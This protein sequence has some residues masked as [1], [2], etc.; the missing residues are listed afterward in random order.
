LKVAICTASSLDGKIATAARDPVRFTSRADRAHLH[1]QR[2]WADAILIGAATIRA[3]D[4]PLLPSAEG[5]QRRQA[6]SR[7]PL[8]IRAVV[9]RSLDLPDGRALRAEEGSPVI[10]FTVAEAGDAASAALAQRG[11]E[12]VRCGSGDVDLS[13]ALKHLATAHGAERVLCEGGGQLNA[14]MLSAGLVDTLYLTLCPVVI[15]GA[16]A[17]TA[18]DGLGLPADALLKAKLVSCEQRDDEVFLCYALSG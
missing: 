11:V 15:G 4:P 12:V 5:R 10:V 13:A 3:E 7:R 16:G 6:E 8:P 9:S 14:A 18:V 17:P 2:D 1:E